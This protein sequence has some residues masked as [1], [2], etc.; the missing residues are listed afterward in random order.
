MIFDI[1]IGDFNE[2]Q[3]EL[4]VTKKRMTRATSPRRT[5]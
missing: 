3:F 2:A 4:R 1:R 5:A